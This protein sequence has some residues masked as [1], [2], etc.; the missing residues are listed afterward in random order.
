MDLQSPDND[1]S[2]K[3]TFYRMRGLNMENC[4]SSTDVYYKNIDEYKVDIVTVIEH[5]ISKNERLVFA[6]VAEKA[7]ITR[8]I[9][10]EYPELRNYILHKIT[11]CK[12]IHAINKKINRAVNSLLKSNKNITFISIINKCR[13]SSDIIYQNQYIKDQIRNVLIQNKQNKTAI[14]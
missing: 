14:K 2:L 8:F 4:L 1:I 6:I 12:E 10:R 7:D 13:F 11:Y 3:C 9:I 5:M